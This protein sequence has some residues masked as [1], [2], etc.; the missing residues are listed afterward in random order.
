MSHRLKYKKSN[1]G[2]F[3]IKILLILTLV[4]STSCTHTRSYNKYSQN[5]KQSPSQMINQYKNESQKRDLDKVIIDGKNE[6]PH[7]LKIVKNKKVEFWMN[8]FSVRDKARFERF[9]KNG[10][11][12]RP[13][14]EKTFED[15]GLPKELY[16]VGLIE[17]GYYLGAKSHANAVGPWQFIKDTGKRYGLTI[18]KGIDER[19]SIVKSTQAAALFFQD[20]YN[21]FGSWELALSAYNAGE[22]GII[23]RI[24]GANTRDYYELSRK[25]VIPKETR[26]YIPKVIAAME[27]LKDPSRY[28]IKIQKSPYDMF[29][30]TKELKLKRSIKIDTLAKKTGVPVNAIK[31]LNPDLSWRTIPYVRGGYN[32]ILPNKNYTALNEINKPVKNDR[33]LVKTKSFKRTYKVKRGD[34][35]IH[36]ARKNGISTQQLKNANALK[37][38]RIYVGQRLKL[39][40]QENEKYVYTVR[41][42]DNL[43][44]I[45]R[46]N[47]TSIS[48]ILKVNKLKKKTIYV[49]QKLYLPLSNKSHYI[50]RKG[51]YLLKIAQKHG[52]SVSKL[53]SLNGIAKSKIYPG[54]KLIVEN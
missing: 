17:S 20:L 18:R 25:K 16:Y 50:V 12:Y 39:P 53:K 26:H 4:I 40:V 31:K 5:K 15:Y 2:H 36:I 28:N 35:L 33:H 22:Y 48:Q 23:R 3:V 14:I 11:K 1:K 44:R 32:I 51:D 46:K 7:F 8:Y 9:I 47:H 34:N 24:R 49:G 27:L 38:N 52:M 43:Y 10:E 37:S 13:I 45:A 6:K 42:G 21:I 30:N 29:A 19:K 54:Q 41:S